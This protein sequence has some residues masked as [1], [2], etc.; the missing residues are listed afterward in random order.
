[1]KRSKQVNG[2]MLFACFFVFGGFFGKMRRDVESFVRKVERN[3]VKVESFEGKVETSP[4]N[5]ERIT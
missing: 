5:V 1:M 3:E 2:L 4:G